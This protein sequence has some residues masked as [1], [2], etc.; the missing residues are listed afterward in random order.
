M[1]I[2][3]YFL[4]RHAHSRE[5]YEQ[6]RTHFPSGITHDA[7]AMEPFPI[8]IDAAK[9]AYKWDVDGNRLIDYWQGHGALLMGHAYGPVVEAVQRQVA[10]GTHYG[11]NHSLEVVWAEHVKRCF[12][13][14]EQ[15]RF[16]SSG[17]EATMLAL[18]LARAYTGKPAVIRFL[19]HFHGWHDLLAQ[20]AESAAVPP[21]VLPDI[22]RSLI[23]LPA[24]IEAVERATATRDDIG[25]VILEP[26]GASY[27]KQPL[28][29]HFLEHLQALCIDRGM[30][31]ICD[32]VVTGFRLAPGGAQERL[33][34]Q[35]DLTCF[36]KI[37]AGGLPGGAVGGR[38]NIMRSL[39]WGDRAWNEEHK[40]KHHG[41][42]N[43]N[44]LAAAAGIATLKT[45][46]TGAPQAYAN[47]LAARLRS[48]LN[49]ELRARNLR[50]CAAYG[51]ASI[52]H[53]I[54]GSPSAFAPG[55]PR[56]ADLA[57]AEL[58]TGIP[59]HLNVPFRLAMLNYGIDLMRGTTAFVSAAHVQEDIEATVAAFGA[60]LDMVTGEGEL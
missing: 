3:D 51:D 16:T 17:T 35:A 55:E 39:A 18:R 52:V 21:G 38:E 12:P 60:A 23:V 34:V 8:A 1:K 59:A 10:R 49:A 54:L 58:K 24:T 33:G 36:A 28:P 22:A 20:G 43:A 26:T 9:G 31:L 13:A 44:P 41:T 29:D 2:L 42:F 45:V 47:D 11:A 5:L 40:I 46:Q 32:E 7:R 6:A 4:R 30:L 56:F 37:L 48:G 14:I 53:I 50:G 57:L 15:L 19:G 25:A 27:G